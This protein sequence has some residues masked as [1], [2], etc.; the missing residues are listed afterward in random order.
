MQMSG[1]FKVDGS[2][3]V[4]LKETD[5]ID[6]AAVTVQLPGGERVP[7][8]FSV[9]EL[10]AKVGSGAA[11]PGGGAL[12]AAG[13]APAL[14]PSASAPASCQPMRRATPMALAASLLCRP[15]VAPPSWTPR[16][17]AQPLATTPRWLCPPPATMVSAARERVAGCEMQV[18]R[19]LHLPC[20]C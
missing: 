9:K 17:A 15:T 5:G 18:D 20:G 4:E 3:N 13:S 14:P 12:L 8:L 10:D 2:G 6:Y 16:A 7:F 1:Q 19:Q 11:L